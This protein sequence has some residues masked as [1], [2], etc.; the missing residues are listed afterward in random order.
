MHVRLVVVVR[1]RLL[2]LGQQQR[3]RSMTV[4]NLV[5]AGEGF[6]VAPR[7][8]SLEQTIVGKL[9]IASCLD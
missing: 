7:C 5:V 1:R 4:P 8:V 6:D 9:G 3:Y 2:L